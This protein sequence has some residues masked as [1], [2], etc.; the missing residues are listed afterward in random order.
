M[1]KKTLIIRIDEDL[2]KKLELEK[3]TLEKMFKKKTSLNEIIEIKLGKEEEV[4]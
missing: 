1:K 2:F 4:E 3:K